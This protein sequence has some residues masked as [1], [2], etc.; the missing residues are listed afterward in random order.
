MTRQLKV[1]V[2]ASVT[3]NDNFS[4]FE[5]N[6]VFLKT[7]NAQFHERGVLSYGGIFAVPLVP[8][9]RSKPHAVMPRQQSPP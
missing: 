3:P 7:L 5:K 8:V 1:G 2:A 6:E 4:V 9:P